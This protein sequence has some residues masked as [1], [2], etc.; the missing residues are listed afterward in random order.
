MKKLLFVLPLF[1]VSSGAFAANCT[2][3]NQAG[4]YALETTMS[5]KSDIGNEHLDYGFNGKLT[6]GAGGVA[7]FN[8]TNTEGTD[9][10]IGDGATWSI[11]ASCRISIEN[12][13]FHNVVAA[14]GGYT[15]IGNP[16]VSSVDCTGDPTEWH[17]DS[18]NKIAYEWAVRGERIN[19]ESTN[20]FT[21]TINTDYFG[22]FKIYK[23]AR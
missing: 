1:L 20:Q 5:R 2:M 12:M 6:L 4:T 22:R 16:I 3:A 18:V 11:N 14:G 17:D 9:G 15:I 19:M 7:S 8:A 13:T 21:N 10:I 23:V